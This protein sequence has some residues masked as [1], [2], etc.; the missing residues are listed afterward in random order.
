LITTFRY[1]LLTAVRDRLLIGVV[2]ALVLAALLGAYLGEATALERHQ[3]SLAYA[4]FATR[5]I[6]AVGLI[7]FVCFHVQRGYDNRE[8][9]LMLSRPISRAQFVVTYWFGFSGVAVLL[10]LVAVIVLPIAGLPDGPGLAV[11]TLSLILE[12]LMVVAFSLFFALTL[13]SAVVSVMASFGFYLL[14]RMT[15]FLIDVAANDWT[16][17]QQ[18]T[19]GSLSSSGVY[20]ISLVMPRLDLFGQTWWLNYGLPAD[21][22]LALIVMQAV[23]YTSLLIAATVFDFQK[24]QF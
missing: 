14:A 1:I 19:T 11:W 2:V 21:L 23:I 4:G 8:I 5:L 10:A 15:G 12:S 18:S 24:R 16:N 17:L 3:M 22:P 9:D 7:V 13:K 20:A 6:L